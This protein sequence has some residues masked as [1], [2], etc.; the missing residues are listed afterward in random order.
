MSSKMINEFCVSL[1][2]WA[3][4]EL[5]QLPEFLP[6]I[7]ARMHEV[8]RFS[9]LN[10]E[11]ETGGPFAAGVFETDSGKLVTIGVNRVVP[12]HCSSAHAEIVALSLAQKT[13]AV[14][15]LG[16]GGASHQ[17]VVNWRPCAM[18]YGAVIWS[19]VRS[20]VIAGSGPELESTTGFDE[21]PIHPD[22]QAELHRR[23][24]DVLDNLL[25]EEACRVFD[26]FA[27][28]HALVYNARRLS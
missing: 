16:G 1:P 5:E 12:G 23:G 6:D 10:I 8:I 11:H 21:G 20:L 14:F 13:L 4:D 28:S 25:K 22:W 2:P 3:V 24:I 7:E 9:R 15:D 17:L 19:G 27:S 18:C 26:Q